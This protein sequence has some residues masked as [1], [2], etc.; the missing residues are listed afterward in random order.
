MRRVWLII[1]LALPASASSL[2]RE[3]VRKVM[4]TA[5]PGFK[6]CYEQQGA[7]LVGK[8]RLTI[9]VS[10]AGL[11]SDVKVDLPGASAE[12]SRCLVDV[13]SRLSFPR[14]VAPWSLVWPVEFKPARV[15]LSP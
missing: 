7:S 12:F 2:D 11:V 4:R 6:R 1:A 15:Q 5:S 10:A 14:G 8:A 13:A 9:S 3:L